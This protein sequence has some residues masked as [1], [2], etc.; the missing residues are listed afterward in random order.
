MTESSGLAYEKYRVLVVDDNG[1]MV[2]LVSSLLRQIGFRDIHTANDG[3]AALK[4]VM[5]APPALIICDI[6]M[7]PLDGVEFVK[8]LRTAG[9]AGK[10]KIPTLFL[11]AHA[12]EQYVKSAIQLEVDG[13]LVKPIKKEV[14]IQRVQ[15]LLLG[16]VPRRP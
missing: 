1:F 7:K 10:D 9:Y 14:L 12:E 4:K 3:E 16:V 2:D 5:Q 8:R 13:F 11:T 15:K 6:N